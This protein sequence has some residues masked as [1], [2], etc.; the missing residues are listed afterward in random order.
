MFYFSFGRFS[1]QFIHWQISTNMNSF[2]YWN[3]FQCRFVCAR[4]CKHIIRV[5]V[6]FLPIFARF[7]KRFYP[8]CWFHLRSFL[9]TSIFLRSSQSSHLHLRLNCRENG[10]FNFRFI[11]WFCCCSHSLFDYTF[12]FFSFTHVL[13]WM[14]C[15]EK[16]ATNNS[17][18]FFHAPHFFCSYLWF[19]RWT[20]LLVRKKQDKKRICFRFFLLN[21]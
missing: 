19:Y 7:K 15:I 13:V 1:F 4:A 3:V 10:S 2:H 20:I 21:R 5:A 12:C 14:W 9:Y 11:R 8:F 17:P 16:E 6:F 18:S